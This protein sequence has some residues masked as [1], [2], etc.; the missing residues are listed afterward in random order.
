MNDL[1]G[2]EGFSVIDD[3][4]I[5]QAVKLIGEKYSQ[6]EY[7]NEEDGSENQ[8]RNGERIENIIDYEGS[9]DGKLLVSL[10]IGREIARL[11]GG[12]AAAYYD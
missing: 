4:L 1:F 9:M 6:Q 5:D 3:E 7:E 11:A 2:E 10:I 12:Q 8:Y